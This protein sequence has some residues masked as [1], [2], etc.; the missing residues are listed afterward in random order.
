MKWAE[1]WSQLSAWVPA[2][3]P[4]HL[5]LLLQLLGGP[6]HDVDL[7]GRQADGAVDRHILS[8][9]IG[10]MH[11]QVELWTRPVWGW[12]WCP[13]PTST[14]A[15]CPALKP[16]DPTSEM[17]SFKKLALCRSGSCTRPSQKDTTPWGKLCW[18]SH[19]TTRCFCMS[20]R[21]VT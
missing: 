9:A 16:W 14:A 13:Q 15:P 11:T 7:H 2:L 21:P 8:G 18:A 10:R 1:L 3:L 6:A 12:A 20:G 4:A 17:S 19:A 5:A